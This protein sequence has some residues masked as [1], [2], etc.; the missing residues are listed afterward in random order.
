MLGC[1]CHYQ[2]MACDTAIIGVQAH[3]SRPMIEQQELSV[4]PPL[5]HP[6]ASIS[7]LLVFSQI[8]IVIDQCVP[9]H[10]RAPTA[11]R[12]VS[13]IR[14]SESSNKPGLV[15]P[16]DRPQRKAPRCLLPLM[17]RR[18]RWSGDDRVWRIVALCY[19]CWGYNHCTSS[20]ESIQE[21]SS[22]RAQQLQQE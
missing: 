18:R 20:H 5:L 9:M 16:C 1:F 12:A 3:C 14:P 8:V 13:R 22:S 4:F 17:S 19:H 2:Q 11:V 15:S 6:S 10:R 21:T 7:S